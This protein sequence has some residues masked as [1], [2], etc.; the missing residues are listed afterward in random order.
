MK[1]KLKEL[2]LGDYYI[3]KLEKTKVEVRVV[4]WSLDNVILEHRETPV[5]ANSQQ[6]PISGIARIETVGWDV[7][8]ANGYTMPKV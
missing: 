7:L 3:I 5:V 2:V 6:E 8:E 1:K 4:G